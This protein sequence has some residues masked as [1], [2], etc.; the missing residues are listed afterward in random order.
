MLVNVEILVLLQGILFD[1]ED[2]DQ[3]DIPSLPPQIEPD[4]EP[5]PDWPLRQAGCGTSTV[6]ADRGASAWPFRNGA[7]P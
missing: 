4:V 1:S 6:P 3:R 5:D 2:F 7:G